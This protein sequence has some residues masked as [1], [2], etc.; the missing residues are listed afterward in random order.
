LIVD[1]LRVNVMERAK[2]AQAR[3]LRCTRDALAHA[4]MH[5]L[6]MRIA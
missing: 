5:L 2:H 3:A 6:A 1:H 4:P